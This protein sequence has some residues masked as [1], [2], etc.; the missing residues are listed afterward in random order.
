MPLYVG[1]YLA[2]TSHLNRADHGS[3]LLLIMHYW[4]HGG[5]PEG[6]EALASIAKV[7]LEEWNHTV[8][9]VV[10][11]FF[12]DGWQH[13]RID[14]ELAKKDV[15]HTKRLIASQKGVQA[16]MALGQIN[17]YHG[18]HVV[19]R[20][21]R[22][23]KNHTDIT[24]TIVSKKDSLS[25]A[26]R[27]SVAAVQQEPPEPVPDFPPFP[28]FP[29]EPVPPVPPPEPAAPPQAAS[30]EAMA[31]ETP[32]VRMAMIRAKRVDQ[33][34]M[35]EYSELIRLKREVKAAASA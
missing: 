15:V 20:L 18:N 3:Y 9:H 14:A 30:D 28:P 6:D 27:Q 5:L 10:Q 8:K 17:G 2:D 32:E 29:A 24:T 11:A 16:R 23:K 25:T 21:V 4:A 34:T 31:S 26:S 7:P 12:H 33:I 13:R 19:N 22:H 35:R 1:D